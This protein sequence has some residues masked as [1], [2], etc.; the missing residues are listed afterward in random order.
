MRLFGF[1]LSIVLLA[2][3]VFAQSTKVP[4]GGLKHN[5]KEQV[6]I[7]AGSLTF[8][9]GNGSAEFIGEVLAKQG[10]LKI[11]TERLLVEYVKKGTEITGNVD[12]M[13]AIGDVTL[14]N[15]EV[16]A[17]GQK[18]IYTVTTGM[19]KMT[20]NV[21]LTQGPNAIAGNVLNIDLNTGNA[22]FEGRVR[23]ILQPSS[24]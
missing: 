20:G 14:S 21:L 17:E 23:T 24:N 15:G 3:P 16:A 2:G 10:S 12:K 8:S 5:A 9:Q 1:V 22:V 13:T 19:V 18:A 4:F 6:E 11:A 7:T